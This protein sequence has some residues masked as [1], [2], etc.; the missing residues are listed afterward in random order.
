MRA[1]VRETRVALSLIACSTA[2]SLAPPPSAV[3]YCR[4]C[5]SLGH[6]VSLS[7]VHNMPVVGEVL[8]GGNPTSST[9]REGRLLPRWLLLNREVDRAISL[10]NR[11][12]QLTASAERT[13]D[14][15]SGQA[16]SLNEA[17]VFADCELIRRRL[18][19]NGIE[20]VMSSKSSSTSSSSK[21]ASLPSLQVWPTFPGS[22]LTLAR[23]EP[24]SEAPSPREGAIAEA[25]QCADNGTL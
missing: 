22:A 11:D 23:T 5:F 16:V 15:Y 14:V 10:Q 19:I 8:V 1:P 12:A 7:A 20:D 9:R 6:V 21:T 17:G 2:V 3:F 4:I 25:L 24:R 18:E 13:E